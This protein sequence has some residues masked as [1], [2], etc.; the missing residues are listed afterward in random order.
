[1]GQLRRRLGMSPE[2]F[3]PAKAVSTGSRRADV[4]LEQTEP[5]KTLATGVS[6]TKPCPACN[7]DGSL[8]EQMAVEGGYAHSSERKT[9]GGYCTVCHGTGTS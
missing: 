2:L 3:D 6:V 9:I 8:S 4:L 1:M 5:A 7:G